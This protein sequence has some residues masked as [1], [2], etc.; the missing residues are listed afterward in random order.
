MA[1]T[2]VMSI[3]GRKNSGKTSMVVALCGEFVKRGHKVGTIKHG[4]HPAMV[5]VEGK[6]TWRHFHEGKAHKT[7]ID[8]PNV[9][10]M[11]ERTDGGDPIELVR[12]YMDDSDIVLIEGFKK[13]PIP[14]VE[15]YRSGVSEQLLYQKAGDLAPYWVAVVTDDRQLSVPVPVFHFGDTSWLVNLCYVVWDQAL[16]VE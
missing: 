16:K 2:R 6:D 13:A 4:H 14:K 9:R 10:A 15:V 5:D 8:S 1:G 11:F 3:V 12:T 7:L